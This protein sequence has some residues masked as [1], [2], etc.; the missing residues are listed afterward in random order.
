MSDSIQPFRNQT[1]T[2]GEVTV[3][4][5]SL[6]MFQ[7]RWQFN[8]IIENKG[9]SDIHLAED[10]AALFVDRGDVFDRVNGRV[11]VTPSLE[12]IPA[13]TTA[14]GLVAFDAQPTAD[15]RVFSLVYGEGKDALTFPFPLGDLV[16]QVPPPPTEEPSATVSASPS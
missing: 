13:G 7:P 4:M 10:G 9:A 1:R 12:T 6:F 15:N 16:T 2:D 11:V 8:V 3:R 14:E 5:D